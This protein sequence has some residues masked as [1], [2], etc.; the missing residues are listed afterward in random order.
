MQPA[1][2]GSGIV[3][4]VPIVRIRASVYPPTPNTVAAMMHAIAHLN[5]LA[6]IVSSIAGFMIGWVWYSPVM[7]SKPWM[8]EMKF[9]E[10]TMKAAAAKGMGKTLGT[11]FVFTAV[12]TW[13]LAV[14]IAAHGSAGW[15]A[16]A[17]FGGFVGVCL[18]G[19][20]AAVNYQFEQRSWKLWAIN[21]GHEVAVCV[22]AGAILGVWR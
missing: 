16:G 1:M 14:L 15:L 5:Y 8:A 17:K 3:P 22:V 19:A 6:V 7:F 11:A 2:S 9:D 12:M 10:A 4:A 21:V 18:L 20:T 13:A